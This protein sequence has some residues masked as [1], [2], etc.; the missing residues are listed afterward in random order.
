MKKV[1]I[2]PIRIGY[3]L[4]EGFG[5]Q[6]RISQTIANHKIAR[7]VSTNIFVPIA[8]WD[9]ENQSITVTNLE[10]YQKN[11]EL[12]AFKLAVNN[13]LFAMQSRGETVTPE[14]LQNKIRGEKIVTF[15]DLA[16][17]LV[18]KAESDLAKNLIAHGTYKTTKKYTKLF[19]DF[20]VWANRTNLL[21]LEITPTLMREFERYLLTDR[22]HAQNTMKR[23][24]IGIV[25]YVNY[26]FKNGYLNTNPL[27][28]YTLPK[29]EKKEVL[30]LTEAE[31]TKLANCNPHSEALKKCRDLFVFQSYTGLAYADFERAVNGEYELVE[32]EKSEFRF[33]LK[34][35]RLKTGVSFSIPM[36]SKPLAIIQKYNGLKNLPLMTNQKYNFYLKELGN[37][38][39]I[40]PKKMCTHIAR[41][42]CGFFLLNNG[43]PI[44][45]VAKILG[46]SSCLVTERHYAKVLDTKIERDLKTF[47]QLTKP[48]IIS[49]I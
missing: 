38:I 16:T 33:W 47:S 15:Q 7:S 9:K 3:Y 29:S 37:L 20:L 26:A 27:L 4:R 1:K 11:E 25:G 36:L 49:T 28:N 44:E 18:N 31:L 32:N 42:T 23:E 40:A 22:K 39:G 8:Q 19:Q 2:N 17:H 34:G 10:S 45:T 14:S 12:K 13:E 43:V 21:L 46:H 6:C 30:H 48:L 41:K 5:I 24:V 35:E